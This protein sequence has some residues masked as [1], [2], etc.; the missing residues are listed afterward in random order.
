MI[1]EMSD[2]W[3]LHYEKISAAARFLR[4]EF[5]EGDPARIFEQMEC[6]IQPDILH[7]DPDVSV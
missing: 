5:R 6:R 3:S 2:E 7:V 4:K 1:D